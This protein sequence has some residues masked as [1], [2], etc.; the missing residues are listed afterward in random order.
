M[1][2]EDRTGRDARES[3]PTGVWPLDHTAD[4]G[5][6]VEAP[7]LNELFRRAGAGSLWLAVGVDAWPEE[8]VPS[9]SFPEGGTGPGHGEG[10]RMAAH[11]KRP[12]TAGA[13]E[14]SLTLEEDDLPSLL[15]SWCRELLYWNEVEGFL[16]TEVTELEVAGTGLRARIRGQA[17]PR[18]PLREIKGVTWHGLR[19]ESRKDGWFARIIYDV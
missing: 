19:V 10:G 9:G 13:E 5:I 11:A 4:I 16:A 14:R 2:R 8:E 15:R 1:T 3:G 7:T 12:D 6:E 18:E 17:A